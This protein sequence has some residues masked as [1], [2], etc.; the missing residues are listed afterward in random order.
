MSSKFFKFFLSRIKNFFLVFWNLFFY[1]GKNNFLKLFYYSQLLL[2]I[3]LLIWPLFFFKKFNKEKDR[4]NGSI[5]SFI[6]SFLNLKLALYGIGIQFCHFF[7]D[8]VWVS[9]IRQSANLYTELLLRQ[10]TNIALP[11]AFKEVDLFFLILYHFFMILIWGICIDFVSYFFHAKFFPLFEQNIRLECF[12]FIL[13][14]SDFSKISNRDTSIETII[15]ELGDAIHEL[16]EKVFLTLIP[17]TC[18]VISLMLQVSKSS[19]LASTLYL[20]ITFLGLFVCSLVSKKIA[21]YSSEQFKAQSDL[22]TFIVD[23]LRH[24][25]IVILNRGQK[26]E[27][28]RLFQLQEKETRIHYLMNIWVGINRITIIMFVLIIKPLIIW[29]ILI[30]SGKISET[31][32]E[33]FKQLLAI[34]FTIWQLYSRFIGV[35]KS[36]GQA[37]KAF[38]DL[39]SLKNNEEKRGNEVSIDKIETIEGKN[40]NLSLDG[41][42]IL[43]NFSF[44]WKIGDK[45]LIRGESGSGK[46]TLFLLISG[47]IKNYEGSVLIN[48][49]DIKEI[50]NLKEYILFISQGGALFNRSIK[51]NIELSQENYDPDL[52]KFAEEISGV[53]KFINV[54]NKGMNTHVNQLSGGQKQRVAIMRGILPFLKKDKTLKENILILL[55]EPYTGLDEDTR[56]EIENSLRNVFPKCIFSIISHSNEDKIFF[57]QEIL[58]T[59]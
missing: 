31:N 4:F 26:L 24:F 47:L 34:N 33:F 9:E 7:G 53:S 48:G 11:P 8:S 42:Q 18:L 41:R 14:K 22:T 5:F 55:D 35:S 43:K 49:I 44:T 29:K 54:L 37:Q 15:S 38:S 19:F 50:N 25:Y 45:I 1:S 2:L 21:Y 28:K 23:S 52:V 30:F 58:F 39:L 40:I 10:I 56:K 27:F 17:G 51:D 13:Y 46:T 16:M 32:I 12:N 20:F 36:A 6:L 3:F 57:N 59:K